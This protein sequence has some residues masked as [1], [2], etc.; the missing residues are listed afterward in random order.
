MASNAKVFLKANPDIYIWASV[1]G[2]VVGGRGGE[3]V[4]I[5]RK[6]FASKIFWG[7][8][9]DGRPG[10][11]EGNFYLRLYSAVYDMSAIFSNTVKKPKVT[12][13]P[14]MQTSPG[15]LGMSII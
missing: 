3:R 7:Y 6:K 15:I 14:P 8:I 9:W 12:L 4:L 10:G 11:G 5:I 1:F 2:V 13:L